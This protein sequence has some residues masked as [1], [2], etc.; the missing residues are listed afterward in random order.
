MTDT[1]DTVLVVATVPR[2]L[3]DALSARYRLQDHARG[4]GGTWPPLSGVSVALTTSMAGADAAL[5]DALPDLKL[6]A[7][8]GVGLDK[9][10]LEAAKARGITVANTPDV[11]TEDTAD[12]AIALI[13]AVSR[14]IVRADQFMRA[15]RWATERL[16]P[17]RRVSGKVCGIVGLGRIGE[18][19]AQRAAGLGLSVRY[20][21]PREKPW[22]P[23]P[24]VADVAE[25]ARQSDFLVLTCPGG[26]ATQNLV[27]AAV[28]EALG[29]NGILINIS[30][31]SVVDE[32][33]L[34][35]A[36]ASGGI[37]GAGLDVFAAEPQFDQALL[38][39]ENVVLQPHYA[40]ITFETRKAII[41]LLQTAIAESFAKK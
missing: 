21:G 12:F 13:F 39:F 1:S 22:L 18:I 25:L 28:L 3:R 24:F 36:L 10:D 16:V 19:V 15:G 26:P 27:D 31:G 37:A 40:S 29:P 35:A 17:S 32:A 11:L 30:R 6:I 34:I 4:P 7:C 5:M 2:D 20:S 38:A 8:Q 9:I 23:Y 14:N 41:G 33:A